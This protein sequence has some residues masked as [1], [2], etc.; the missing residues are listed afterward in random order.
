MAGE[1]KQQLDEIVFGYSN[2]LDRINASPL[3]L[4]M[5]MIFVEEFMLTNSS[6]V[7]VVFRLPS[8]TYLGSL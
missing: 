4:I 7:P 3:P 5:E 2:S 8:L 6:L 1:W